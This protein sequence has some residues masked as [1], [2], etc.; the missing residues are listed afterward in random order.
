MCVYLSAKEKNKTRKEGNT[1]KCTKG[2]QER[3]KKVTGE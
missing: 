3:T 2:G 1:N